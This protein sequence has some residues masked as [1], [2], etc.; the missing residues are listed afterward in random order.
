MLLVFI[1]SALE[2]L[3]QNY[4]QILLLNNSFEYMEFFFVFFFVFFQRHTIYLTN[5]T[6]NFEFAGTKAY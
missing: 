1:R 3:S 5:T 2:K 4:L 6:R